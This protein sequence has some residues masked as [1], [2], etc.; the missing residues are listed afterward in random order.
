MDLI[1]GS[2]RS[3]GEGNGNPL[4]YSCLGNPWTEE[5]GG[6]LSLGLQRVWFDW[7]TKQQRLLKE[8]FSLPDLLGLSCE[9]HSLWQVHSRQWLSVSSALS[10]QPPLWNWMVLCVLLFLKNV[11][12]IRTEE[13]GREGWLSASSAIIP[14]TY[15]GDGGLVTKLYLTLVTPWTI[16]GKASLSM[17]FSRQEHWSGLPF[18]PPGDL[19]HP[20][21][22]S[23]SS[24]LQEDSLLLS[25]K[26]S[27]TTIYILSKEDFLELLWN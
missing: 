26:G 6:L 9:A 22:K 11:R 4:Q 13:E 23:A 20:G 3:P 10:L 18:P 15:S 1:P 2:R 16:A 21:L 8:Q 17:G 27:P 25:H 14:A 19:P 24:A 12:K 5:P 7:V